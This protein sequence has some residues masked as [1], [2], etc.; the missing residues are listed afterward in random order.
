M[1]GRAL[2]AAV[3]CFEAAGKHV[4]RSMSP[5]LHVLLACPESKQAYR[6]WLQQLSAPLL[7]QLL[8]VCLDT[9]DSTCLSRCLDALVAVVHADQRLLRE[10]NA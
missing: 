2:L 10:R 5:V 3:H 4:F 8:F 1:R 6:V 7:N 9:L